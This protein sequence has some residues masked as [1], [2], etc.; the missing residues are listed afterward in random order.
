VECAG[1]GLVVVSV[2]LRV[3]LVGRGFLQSL[4][5]SEDDLQE[6]FF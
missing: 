1:S 4:S 6:W 3:V 5:F 2:Q